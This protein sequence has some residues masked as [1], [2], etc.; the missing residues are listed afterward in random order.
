ML[1]FPCTSTPVVSTNTTTAFLTLF[2]L[3]KCVLT[4]T[5]TVKHTTL[6]YNLLP[7]SK[8]LQYILFVLFVSTIFNQGAHLT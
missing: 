3:T 8:L 5:M 7:V 6:H 2:F 1:T 4:I